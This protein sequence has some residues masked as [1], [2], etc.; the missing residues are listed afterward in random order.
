LRQINVESLLPTIAAVEQ[1]YE[2]LKEVCFQSHLSEESSVCISKMGKW[3]TCVNTTLKAVAHIVQM[4]TKEA[5]GL[6]YRKNSP[7]NVNHILFTLFLD[8]VSQ[9]IL[10]NP[11]DFEFS[12]FY[13]IYLFDCQYIQS[14]TPF[15]P[16]LQKRFD[17]EHRN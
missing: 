6:A 2:K 17:E 11:Y 4:I 3:M 7:R 14:S 13:L 16:K 9:L 1:S 15:I 10:Q 8:C 5:S 12:T